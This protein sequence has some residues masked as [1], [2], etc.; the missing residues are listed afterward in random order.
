MTVDEMNE[1]VDNARS[2]SKVNDVGLIVMMEYAEGRR[3]WLLN[4]QG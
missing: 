3:E 4:G 2:D 1:N